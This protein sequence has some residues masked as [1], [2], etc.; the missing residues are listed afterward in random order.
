MLQVIVIP[1]DNKVKYAMHHR[2][3]GKPEEKEEQGKESRVSATVRAVG[4]TQ[5]DSSCAHMCR[6]GTPCSVFVICLTLFYL[7]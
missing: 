1:F 7:L 4:S 5:E 3:E 6:I 2:R